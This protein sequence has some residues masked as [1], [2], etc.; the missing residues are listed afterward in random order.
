MDNQ[1]QLTSKVDFL[2]FEKPKQG[3]IN[4]E[5]ALVVP[6]Y[7]EFEGLVM[8]I[9]FLAGFRVVTHDAK[10]NQNLRFFNFY[11]FKAS[12]ASLRNIFVKIIGLKIFCVRGLCARALRRETRLTVYSAL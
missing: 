4:S 9:T 2:I 11:I 12:H 5:P 3:G 6:R 1:I 10:I 7:N 8:R